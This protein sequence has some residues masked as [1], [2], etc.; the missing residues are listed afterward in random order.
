MCSGTSHR[1]G[2]PA[3][4]ADPPFGWYGDEAAPS[5]PR[6]P[7][8]GVGGTLSSSSDRLRRYWSPR[9]QWNLTKDMAISPSST[10]V[11]MT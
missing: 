8:A 3:S 7:T 11:K 5:T 2:L 10:M 4:T 9:W 1:T 6:S